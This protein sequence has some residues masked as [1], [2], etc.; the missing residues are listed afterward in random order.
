MTNEIQEELDMLMMDIEEKMEKAISSFSHELN[1][2]RTGRA[3]P[4]LLDSILV[5]Y[6]GVLTP[7][8]QMATVS[9][10]EANQLY[11]KP[12][13][14]ST[15]KDIEKAINASNLGLT[16]QNDG[17]GI[18][19]VIPQMTEQRRRELCKDVS[20]MAENAKV[21]VRN[22]RRD[23]NDDL[24]KLDLPED[25]EKAYLD[26]IQKTTDKYVGKIANIADEK[27]K[28]LLTI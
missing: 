18:R 16:P 24:K 14:K 21:H 4:N 17:V 28:E 3:N 11:I 25:D 19:L 27:E 7:V 22:I 8:K 9:V 15:L 1:T 6:Y 10:P 12:Y 20:K 23:A 2:V 26:D 5:E 13:D